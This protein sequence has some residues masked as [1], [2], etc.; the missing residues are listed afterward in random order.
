MISHAAL[1]RLLRSDAATNEEAGM[2][3][4]LSQGASAS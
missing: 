4:S 2:E 1:W 3:R